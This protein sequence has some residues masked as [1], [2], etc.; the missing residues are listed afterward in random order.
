[1]FKRVFIGGFSQ[2]C[3]I[4]LAYGLTSPDILAGILGFSGH[5]FKSFELKNK[6]KIPML[7][8]HGKDDD[9]ID[10]RM[11]KKEYDNLIGKQ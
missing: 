8:Y 1:L 5:M 7:I 3:A 11:S 10:Y 2:G 9:V 6:S 4:S